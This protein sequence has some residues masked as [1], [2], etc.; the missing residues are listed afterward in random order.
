[1]ATNA[2]A[3]PFLPDKVYG[4]VF[5]QPKDAGLT[6][7][8]VAAVRAMYRERILIDVSHMRQDA[9]DAT[10]RLLA[11]LDAE[12]GADPTGF[13]VIASHSAFR[14]GK[15]AYNLSAETVRRIAAR[16]GVIGLILAQHQLNDGIRDERD[17]DP[18][19]DRR[20]AAPPHRRDRPGGGLPC[21]CR[22]RL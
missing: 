22:H 18:P 15:Q 10:F 4:L 17:E 16:D 3:L 13:P 8:G 21:P 19:A 7:L 20:G 1:M 6:D 14:C 12:H 2:N 9:L 11:E 5:P